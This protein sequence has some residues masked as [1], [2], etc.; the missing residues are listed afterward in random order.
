MAVNEFFTT[1]CNSINIPINRIVSLSI[2]MMTYA[3]LNFLKFSMLSFTHGDSTSIVSWQPAPM[4][5]S[6]N[7]KHLIFIEKD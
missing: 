1:I 7:V 3:L 2:L 4:P 5:N 6:K